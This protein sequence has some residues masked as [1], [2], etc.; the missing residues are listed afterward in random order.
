MSTR[1]TY[2]FIEA[3]RPGANTTTV[4][5]HHD[6]YPE[7]AAVYLNHALSNPSKGN[8]A[9]Q[10]IRAN[11]GAEITKSHAVHGDTEFCYDIKGEGSDAEIIAYAYIYNGDKRTKRSIFSGLLYQFIDQHSKFISD[12]VPFRKIDDGWRSAW[13]N[14]AQARLALARPVGNLKGWKGRFEGSG[15]WHYS[16]EEA[17]RVLAVFP[18]L[19]TDEIK[20]LVA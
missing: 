12:H 10:F 15:N 18:E 11:D 2:R 13:Y 9:T 20:E 6:G 14:L 7:G 19:A 1:A 8:M 16:V 3:G 17:K 5:I 4:Y